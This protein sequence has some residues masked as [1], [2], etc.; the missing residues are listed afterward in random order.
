[1]FT[2]FLNK[3]LN[4]PIGGRSNHTLIS[5]WARIYYVNSV[6]DML[7][8]Y[9]IG[10]DISWLYTALRKWNLCTL[11]GAMLILHVTC[12]TTPGNKSCC[13]WTLRMRCTSFALISSNA[14]TDSFAWSGP[15]FE[16]MHF[17]F[18]LAATFL[19]APQQEQRNLAL[20]RSFFW[21]TA[22]WVWNE[23]ILDAAIHVYVCCILFINGQPLRYSMRSLLVGHLRWHSQ[24]WLAKLSH[25]SWSSTSTAQSITW[26]HTLP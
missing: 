9:L 24:T 8:V 3:P 6:S 14:A 20:G 19:S 13:R 15:N 22:L 12:C 25:V 18:I 17:L 1:M 21:C 11:E 2:K 5:K 7:D 4:I 10:S 23:C 16:P 26:G